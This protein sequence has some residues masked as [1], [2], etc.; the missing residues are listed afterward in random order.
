MRSEEVVPK[1]LRLSCLDLATI[2][3]GSPKY[4]CEMSTERVKGVSPSAQH[5]L[6]LV[7]P[8]HLLGFFV[9]EATVNYILREAEFAHDCRGSTAQ[10][11]LSPMP[12]G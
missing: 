8:R 5:G 1:Q 2:R 4:G 7:C 3:K 10:V 12:A 6:A 9:I 11:V